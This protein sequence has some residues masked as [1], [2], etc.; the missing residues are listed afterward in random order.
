MA[1]P[2]RTRDLV[3]PAVLRER[4][5][6]NCE[7][8]EFTWKSRIGGR[9][10]VGNVAG[11]LRKSDG[12]R[13]VWI[14]GRLYLSHVVAWAWMTGEWPISEVDH[15][16]TDKSDSR[17][18]NLRLAS[19]AQNQTNSK[20]YRNNTSGFRGVSKVKGRN[21]WVATIRIDNKPRKLGRF[22]TPDEAGAAYRAA[23]IAHYGEYSPFAGA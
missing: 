14:E 12:Y 16:N 2:K 9:C 10:K 4:L 17:W 22:G 7:S 11:N 13:Q 21:L 18:S 15:R 1:G 3:S 8:G 23:S 20:L 19:H 5:N 6:Y